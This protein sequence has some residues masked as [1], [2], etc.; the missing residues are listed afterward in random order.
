MLTPTPLKWPSIEAKAYRI[1][2][3]PTSVIHIAVCPY[4]E[5]VTGN[6]LAGWLLRSTIT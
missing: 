6:E 5:T 2:K 1:P 4:V 3:R